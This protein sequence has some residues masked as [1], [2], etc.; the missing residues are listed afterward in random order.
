MAKFW[1]AIGITAGIS[2]L[3]LGY[4]ALMVHLG[5]SD[6]LWRTMFFF[7]LGA[8]FLFVLKHEEV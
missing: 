1:M 3:A 2:L 4:G 6:N 8:F 7:Q 5:G